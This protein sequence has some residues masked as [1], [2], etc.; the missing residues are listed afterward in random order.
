MNGPDLR[1]PRAG[2]SRAAFTSY[3]DSLR[4]R[5]AKRNRSGVG[6]QGQG[7]IVVASRN[8]HASSRTNASAFEEFQ[9]VAVAFVNPTHNV[10]LSSFGMG[11]QNQ[12]APPPAAGALEFAEIA[13]WT[14]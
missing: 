8:M 9:Q 13:V 11:E 7:L 12:A 14:G 3:P 10:S 5:T 1:G 4:R 2:M 6:G